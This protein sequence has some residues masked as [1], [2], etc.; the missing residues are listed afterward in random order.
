MAAEPARNGLLRG[1]GIVESGLEPPFDRLARLAVGAT[2]EPICVLAFGEG[3]SPWVKGYSGPR[4]LSPADVLPRCPLYDELLA[5][6]S[7]TASHGEVAGAAIRTENGV[8]VGAVWVRARAP[9]TWR[10]D[11]LETLADIAQL[12][13]SELVV[14]RT[15]RPDDSC[16]LIL[17]NIT[18]AC[19]FLGRDWCFNYVNRKAAEVF[20]HRAQDLIGKHI[21]TEFPEGVG[22]PFDRAYRHAM[23]EQV[24]TQVEEYYAPWNGWFQNRIYPSPNGL[25]VFFQDVTELRRAE[26]ER[27]RLATII[28]TM[29]AA[30]VVSDA[31]GALSYVNRAGRDLLGIRDDAELARM[32]LIGLHALPARPL[33]SGTAIPAALR[34]GSW[35]GEA[36]L[37]GTSGKR[38]QVSEQLLWHNAPAPDVGYFSLI[39]RDLTQLELAEARSRR[40]AE[41]MAQAE[42][43]AHF[44]HWVWDIDE[45]RVSWSAELF[46]IYGLDAASFEASLDGYLARVHLQ[47]RQRV[48]QTIEQ[49]LRDRRSFTFEERI[50]RPDESLRYLRSWGTVSIGAE[51]GQRQLFGACIDMTELMLATDGLRRTGEWLEVALNGVRVA[52]C[53]WDVRTK[54]S[55]WSAGAAQVFGLGAGEFEVSFDAYLEHVHRDDREALEEAIRVSV[56][57]GADLELEHRVIASDGSVRWVIGRARMVRDASGKVCRLIGTVT[58]VTERHHA[59]DERLRLLDELRQAQ[60]ME[61]IGRLAA[62]VAHDFNNH[63][64]I[65]G[66]AAEILGQQLQQ[67]EETR[68]SVESIREAAQRAAALTRQLLTLS[69]GQALV[70][71]Q[72]DLNEVVDDGCKLFRRLLPDK[73]ELVMDL[74]PAPTKVRADRGQ[75]EQVLL[76]LIVNARD[77][78]PRGGVVTVATRGNRDHATLVVRDTGCGMSEDLQA[79]IFEPFFTTKTETG[80]TGLGL[81]T[82]YGIVA[83]LG[84]D[85]GIE[86]RPGAGSS[87]MIRLPPA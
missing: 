2:R 52:V 22:Q 9:R 87:F 39:A 31:E 42:R 5:G 82:A 6:A 53:E 79:H 81:A 40:D 36:T 83:Q 75:L 33:L 54:D 74:A 17:E 60:K 57:T 11:V 15:R 20:G 69:R 1:Y 48:R 28:E 32:G 14:R 3:P 47:D 64:T 23:Q 70:L 65:I 27:N 4:D 38:I 26:Q 72:V 49:A 13:Q 67:S 62:G 66:S 44:G 50:V 8:A 73:V 78:M 30:V 58:D 86:S 37:V 45:N 12:A 80:G 55:R 56:D 16:A 43:L 24:F 7:L 18:D 85:I 59:Q 77:A 84:G 21:W 35:S 10:N 29:P 68:S 51:R 61:A 46:R 25:A 41:V 19:F 76:N 34:T 63:L 71:S